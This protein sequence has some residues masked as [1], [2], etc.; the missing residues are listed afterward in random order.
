[1]LGWLGT[2]LGRI[3]LGILGIALFWLGIEQATTLGLLVMM[4]GLVITIAA[5]ALPPLPEST[6]VVRSRRGP[7]SHA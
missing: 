4:T 1:M 5:A 2:P 3:F 6:A 7:P